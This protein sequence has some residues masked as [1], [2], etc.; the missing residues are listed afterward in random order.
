M[1]K[2]IKKNKNEG[3][4]LLEAIIAIAVLLVAVTSAS[5]LVISSLQGLHMTRNR[6][7]AA[8]LA[9]EGIEV[10]RNI[11]D[12]NWINGNPYNAGLGESINAY[13][14]E[15]NGTGLISPP[16]GDG[17]KLYLNPSG[18]YV[19]NSAGA[20]TTPFER[21]IFITYLVNPEDDPA[22]DP[23]PPLIQIESVVSWGGAGGGSITVEDRLYDWQ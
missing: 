4:T 9:Q 6:V 13:C 16:C 3:F 15:Y 7:T 1:L 21:R 8:Y 12:T 20:D 23:D 10:V 22:V 14:I 11:R 19:H 18:F 2:Y 17:Y 5:G